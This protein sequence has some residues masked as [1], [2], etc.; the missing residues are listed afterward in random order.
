MCY[1]RSSF[2]TVCKNNCRYSEVVALRL[3]TV[4]SFI[5][6]SAALH[7][8]LQVTHVVTD[9]TG[10]LTTSKELAVTA[11]VIEG[12]IHKQSDRALLDDELKSVDHKTIHH[13]SINRNMR[14]GLGH[15][16]R[17]DGKN[18]SDEDQTSY[19]NFLLH[20]ALCN[21]VS[22]HRARYDPV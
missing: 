5:H 6:R 1:Q 18:V 9:K 15:L 14:C 2:S 22:L 3:F 16:Q 8:P 7:P 19:H 13:L 12:T 10:T 11:A 17:N 21:D 20:M 4:Q